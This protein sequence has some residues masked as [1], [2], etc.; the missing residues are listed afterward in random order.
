MTDA[1]IAAWKAELTVSYIADR[2]KTGE[3]EEE[4]T[5]VT[6]MQLGALLPDGKPAPGNLLS[7]VCVDDEPVGWLWIGPRNPDAPEAYW[8]WDVVIDESQRGKG[9]G[10]QAMV[11][12]E[13]QALEAGASELGLNVF[14]INTIARRLY[15]SLGYET[16]AIQMRKLL[17]KD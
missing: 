8:V 14:G 1:E 7:R 12:A 13:Q 16:T 17:S 2:M 10:R 6:D 4:A 9:L 3:S 15:E 11:L 5:R